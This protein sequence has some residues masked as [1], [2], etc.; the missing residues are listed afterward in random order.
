MEEPTPRQDRIPMAAILDNWSE[1]LWTNGVQLD[2]MQDME[3]L[4]VQTRN[5]V[6]EILVRGGQ[7]GASGGRNSNRQR[8]GTLRN[9][10]PNAR[11]AQ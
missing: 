9:V 10:V 5:S 3:K 7:F 11:R 1:H 8:F 6:Y 4:E 2:Q